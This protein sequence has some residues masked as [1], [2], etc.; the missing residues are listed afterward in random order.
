MRACPHL[1]TL[2]S[3]PSSGSNTTK[4]SNI[5]LPGLWFHKNTFR[6]YGRHFP[7]KGVNKGWKD[8][9][10]GWNIGTTA[11][12]EISLIPNRYNLKN[13]LTLTIDGI[14]LLSVDD[15]SVEAVENVKLYVGDPQFQSAN[16]E[17]KNIVYTG[18]VGE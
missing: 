2:C 11:L 14:N 3:L 9:K 5:Y 10:L 15:A 4:S 18:L 12:V 8:L 17:L 16:V 6:L 13:V 1:L 7:G